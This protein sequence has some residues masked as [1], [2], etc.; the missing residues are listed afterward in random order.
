MQDVLSM[1]ER[2]EL[3]PRRCGADRAAG[4]RGFCGAAGKVRIAHYGPHHG[5]EPPISGRLGSGT[6]FFSFC[7]LRCIFCQNYQISHDGMGEEI[8]IEELTDLFFN[9]EGRGCHNINLVSPT[10]YTAHIAVAIR[11]AR[12]RGLKIPIVH[13]TNAYENVEALK[14]LDGLIDIYLPDFKYADPQVAEKLSGV[15]V[16]LSYPDSAREAIL[17]MKRQVGDLIVKRGVAKRGLIMR[18]LV[19]PGGLAG[20]QEVFG[21]AAKNLGTGTFISL[22]SQYY[23]V[24][25]AHTVDLLARKIRQEEYDEVVDY[26]VSEGFDNVFIQELESAPLFVPDFDKTEPFK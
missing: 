26:L 19:L 7:N 20:S 21:W 25:R 13:N 16:S 4:E 8:S 24:H 14:L 18:H 15:P 23:P 1:L 6:I 10:P 11:A 12:E 9:L 5:E 17:E 22:M 2:C 3:C